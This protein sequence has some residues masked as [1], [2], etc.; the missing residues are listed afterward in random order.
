MPLVQ[1]DPAVS[2]VVHFAASL[3]YKAQKDFA[4]FYKSSLLYL[5]FVSSDSLEHNYKLVRRSLISYSD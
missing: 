4:E 3:Y 2:A 1:V 5:C